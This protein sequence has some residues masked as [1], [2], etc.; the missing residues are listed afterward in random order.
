MVDRP[1]IWVTFVSQDAPGPVVRRDPPPAQLCHRTYPF[2]LRSRGPADAHHRQRV[3]RTRTALGSKAGID[4]QRQHI[5]WERT[6]ESFS[7]TVLERDQSTAIDF[8]VPGERLAA[9]R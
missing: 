1:A 9:W 5:A 6:M 8:I 3:P 2:A 4:D 7:P